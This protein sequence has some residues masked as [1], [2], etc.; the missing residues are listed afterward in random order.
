MRRGTTRSAGVCSHRNH[1]N[2][3][4][5]GAFCAL[6]ACTERPTGDAHTQVAGTGMLRIGLASAPDEA[7]D[8]V[9]VRFVVTSSATGQSQEA[10]VFLEEEGL[11]EA[12]DAARAGVRF[13]DWFV[14]L[15]AGDYL[16]QAMPLTQTGAPSVSCSTAMGSASVLSGATTEIV[17]ESACGGVRSGALDV[18]FVLQPTPFIEELFV[19]DSK[20]ICEDEALLATLALGASVDGSDCTWTVSGTPDNVGEESYCLVSNGGQASFSANAPGRYELT[21]SVATSSI[22][23]ALR[24]PVYVS[25]CG[26]G[27]SCPGDPAL[28]DIPSPPGLSSGQ[29]VCSGDE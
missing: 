9:Q 10:T 8:V 28:S 29:C 6:V 14:V 17:L 18:V 11:P 2:W 19:E 12:L 21:V 25:S 24:F 15:N 16:V 26:L 5:L 7:F 1:A 13:A 3:L 4:S 22:S 27:S 20:F 23:T